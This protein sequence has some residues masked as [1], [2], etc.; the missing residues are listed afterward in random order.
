[1]L[2]KLEIFIEYFPNTNIYTLI[3]FFNNY[4]TSFFITDTLYFNDI[5]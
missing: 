4:L 3:I 5:S 2:L 1:M